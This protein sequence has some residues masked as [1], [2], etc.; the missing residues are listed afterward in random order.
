MLFTT[1][2]IS[3]DIL[4]VNIITTCCLLSYNAIIVRLILHSPHGPAPESLIDIQRKRNWTKLK[5]KYILCISGH[6]M[7]LCQMGGCRDGIIFTSMD[8]QCIVFISVIS[9]GLQR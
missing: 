8:N 3:N 2:L 5:I 9:T 1:N 7:T 4:D 6:D